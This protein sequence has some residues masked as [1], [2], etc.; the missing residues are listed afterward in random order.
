MKF[1][2]SSHLSKLQTYLYCVTVPWSSARKPSLFKHREVIFTLTA[3]RGEQKGG[4]EEVKA[5][6]GERRRK[7]KDDYF[8]VVH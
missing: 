6:D 3:L 7:Q 5:N 1:D 8:V 2:K 4:R